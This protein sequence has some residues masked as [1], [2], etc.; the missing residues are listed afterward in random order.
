MNKIL[1]IID[2][3]YKNV[4]FCDLLLAISP[5]YQLWYVKK[6]RQKQ[7]KL[8]LSLTQK[9]QYKVLFFLQNSSIWKYDTLY[10]LMAQSDIFEPIVAVSPYNVHLMYDKNECLRVMQ[11]AEQFAVQQGYN[12]ISTYDYS[13][14]RWIDIKKKINPDIVN[15]TLDIIFFT[16]YPIIYFNLN[17]ILLQEKK[18]IFMHLNL[19]LNYQFY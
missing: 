3:L 16:L 18:C 4:T 17:S 8:V 12:Y 15:P 9:K 6:I 14:K 1:P 7:Q 19:L 10:R 2:S 11:R 13:R 5:T